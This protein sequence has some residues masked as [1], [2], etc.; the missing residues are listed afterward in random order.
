MSADYNKPTVADGY[1]DFPASVR[2]TDAANVRMLGEGSNLPDKAVKLNRSTK[3]LEEY[4]SGAGTWEESPIDAE[5]VGGEYPSAFA[6]ASHTHAHN[7]TTSRDASDCHPQAAITGL[8]SALANK[9]DAT[10]QAAD[11]AKLGGY[12]PTAFAPVAHAHDDRYYTEAEVNALLAAAVPAGS[13]VAVGMSSV[14][15]G[16]LECNGA[17]ISRSTYAALFA[18]IGTTW[19]AGDGSTT[20]NLP[21][22][23]G[24]FLRGWDH[25]R[26]VDSG[27][28]LG[29]YQ[30]E[31][32][33]A[34]AHSV[35]TVGNTESWGEG[36][37]A[38]QMT[39]DHTYSSAVTTTVGGTE[40]RPRNRAVMYCIK[41]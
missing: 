34:H 7:D 2:D 37:P 33:K 1:S 19:G 3:H 28:T 4:D 38:S 11:S 22:F 29:S 36:D 27:R 6:G 13:L 5:T 16:Y 41:Y 20:F 17:G 39:S 40:T 8:T 10:A 25:S 26:G 24:E 14:P 32:F 9:L 18:A 23:R 35:Y 30:A 31:A 15:T 21:D 12:V